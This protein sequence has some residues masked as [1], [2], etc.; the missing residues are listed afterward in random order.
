MLDNRATK[1]GR[2]RGVPLDRALGR[3]LTSGGEVFRKRRRS[4]ITGVMGV[5]DDRY[6]RRWELSQAT[7]QR[8]RE[9]AHQAVT[10]LAREHVR[11]ARERLDEADRRHGAELFYDDDR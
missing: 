6:L 9:P 3:C 2:A 10:D 7:Q 8:R 11:I 4:S 5:V 1:P